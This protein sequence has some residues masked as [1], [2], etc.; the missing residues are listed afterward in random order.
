M[1][2]NYGLM[3][4]PLQN[5][6]ITIGPLECKTEEQKSR[7]FSV[8]VNPNNPMK[9]G[10]LLIDDDC[11]KPVDINCIRERHRNNN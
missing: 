10:T 9:S 5:A 3:K 8:I 6:T 11:P 7:P 2:F 1:A 4:S